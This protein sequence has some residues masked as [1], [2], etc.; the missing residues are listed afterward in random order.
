MS[1]INCSVLNCSNNKNGNCYVS[2]LNIGGMGAV[3]E[4][5]TCCASFL[6]SSV[7]SNIATIAAMTG[8]GPD[9]ILC[10]ASN[11]NHNS[12]GYC[13]LNS[14]SVGASN[15]VKYYSQTECLNFES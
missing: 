7:Y 13:E 10:S 9:S 1:Q 15:N 4:A 5:G 3:S 6:N 11:C 14:I 2:M 12:G 8:Q